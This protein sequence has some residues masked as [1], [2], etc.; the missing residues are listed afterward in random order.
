MYNYS[1]IIMTEY[2]INVKDC[3]DD[4]IMMKNI[5][6]E[7]H[8]VGHM[9]KFDEYDETNN[10]FKI[11]IPQKY[12]S[13]IDRDFT[14]DLLGYG[15]AG[16]ITEYKFNDIVSRPINKHTMTHMDCSTLQTPIIINTPHVIR[17]VVIKFPHDIQKM[18]NIGEYLRMV[19]MDMA[20][21]K[22]EYEH[23]T[24][25][26]AR[27]IDPNG[28]GWYNSISI[29]IPD[30]G[31]DS[32]DTYEKFINEST[33]PITIICYSLTSRQNITLNI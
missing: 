7:F 32:Y 11:M 24:E 21:L 9:S 5:N 10:T 33:M 19:P 8:Y 25:M 15:K 22:K 1:Y 2:Y 6:N 30:M 3:V 13:D 29:E 23:P 14:I 18:F 12:L 26:L 20:K 28:Q 17:D 4:I 16:G 31:K 27:G